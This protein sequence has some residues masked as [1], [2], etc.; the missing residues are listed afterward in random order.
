[1][2]LS[3]FTLIYPHLVL[4]PGLEPGTNAYQ[5]PIL[6]LNYRST[7]PF[8]AVLAILTGLEPALRNGQLRAFPDGN[9][10]IELSLGNFGAL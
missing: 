2:A 8:G 6:P 7:A 9:R 5:A 4:R 3:L 1:V 10:I